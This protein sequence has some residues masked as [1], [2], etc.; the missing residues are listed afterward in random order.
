LK[1]NIKLPVLLTP[2]QTGQAD[3]LAIAGGVAS[4]DLMEEAGRAVF[5][6]VIEQFERCEALV[7]CGS[8]N[9]GGDG[10]VAARLLAEAGW[11]VRVAL[12]G[13]KNNL[14][15]D[16]KANAQRWHGAIEAL[17]P[18]NIQNPGLIQNSELI[19]DA[20]LGAGLDRDVKGVLGE[21]IA[22]VNAAKCPVVSVDVP[23]GLDGAT[24]EV[25]GVAVRAKTTVTFFTK[26]PG[27][28]LY[29]GRELCGEVQVADIGIPA[30]VL[31]EIGAK[32][33]ENGP[34]LW[35]LP[36]LAP[37]GHKYGRGH[38][39][40]VSGD[41]LHT[42]AGRL[43]ATAAL[44]AGAGLVTIVGQ[45]PALMV[46]ANHLTSVM[47]AEIN[48]AAGLK[49]LLEDRRKN[50]VVIG[51]A[52]GIGEATRHNVLAALAS[53][54]GLVVDADALTS[55]AQNRE[56]LFAAIK[57]LAGRP[58]VLTPHG[59]E[60]ASLFGFNG[61]QGKL[62][63]ARE[64]ARLSGAVLVLKGADSVIA[65]PDGW[66]AIN[67]NAPATLA[68]AGSGDVLAGIIG[69]FLAQG[70]SARD[71]AAAAVYCHGEAANLFAK[72]GL[73]AEDLPGLLPNVLVS[74]QR[75]GYSGDAPEITN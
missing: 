63:Q 68:T 40:I 54:A 56:E 17:R 3:A 13:D 4:L 33:F 22:Q 35:Q 73:I 29:P 1:Q 42:G 37:G 15:G 46:H 34:E 72:P 49:E 48:S 26:K 6:A 23:S 9:N 60:F 61:M 64:A 7:L 44:R 20:L 14:C 18:K 71:A 47:L 8:G 53:G 75:A 65:A 58:V 25:R 50:A 12:F 2:E 69:G 66:A 27:H 51:P 19:I 43:A 21:V 10:F 39:L 11:P 57:A 74:L 70:M 55:F 28:L 16:A 45:K 36:E 24:G 41:E 32:T 62:E 59:G 5:Q 30:K 38:C 52:A 67:T 31:D